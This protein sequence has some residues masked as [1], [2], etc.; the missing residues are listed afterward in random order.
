MAGQDT[1]FYG[2]VTTSDAQVWFCTKT[3]HHLSHGFKD[4]YVSVRG[5]Q[6]ETGTQ[7]FGLPISEEYGF[8]GNKVAQDFERARL[9][10][11][12]TQGAPWTIACDTIGL[13][14][15]AAN[16]QI[17]TLQETIQHLQ[18]QLAAATTA[19]GQPTPPPAADP[20]AAKALAAM[21]ALK[22]MLGNV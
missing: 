11:D 10:Y 1:G 19:S 6:G 16:V 15:A 2:L 12:P 14:L 8:G 18:Q 21:Q 13:Q 5:N 3:G 4:F 22:T 9:V 17:Q 20:T 7:I